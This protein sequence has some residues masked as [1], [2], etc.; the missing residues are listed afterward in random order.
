VA[1]F[2][3][4]IAT[5]FRENFHERLRNIQIGGVGTLD[6]LINSATAAKVSRDAMMY[7]SPEDGMS[8]N[9]FP[10]ESIDI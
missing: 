5:G 10:F 4:L 8:Q 6:L 7:N 1:K 3:E 9:P 2:G